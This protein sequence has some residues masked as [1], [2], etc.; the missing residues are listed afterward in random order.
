MNTELVSDDL[1]AEID[2]IRVTGVS[3]MN[4]EC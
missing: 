1:S 3:P 2:Y 4:R